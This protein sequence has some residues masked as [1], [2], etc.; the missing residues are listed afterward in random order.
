MSPL[1]GVPGLGS[2]A[3]E[4]ASQLLPCTGM[5][6]SHGSTCALA[7]QARCNGDALSCEE[8]LPTAMLTLPSMGGKPGPPVSL[9]FV[10]VLPVCRSPATICSRPLLAPWSIKGEKHVTHTDKAAKA[11][12]A[13]AVAATLCIS[14]MCVQDQAL[15]AQ[16]MIFTVGCLPI[17]PD[18]VC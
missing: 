12:P 4:I 10:V 14:C 9:R 8:Q 15:Q 7:T 13:A 1:A 2:R 16:C 17:T 3:K 18:W 5:H 11:R 6:S